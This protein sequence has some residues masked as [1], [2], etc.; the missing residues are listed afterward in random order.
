MDIQDLS[1]TTSTFQ[2]HSG[3]FKCFLELP[4]PFSGLQ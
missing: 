1:V 2:Q 4:Q 3:T